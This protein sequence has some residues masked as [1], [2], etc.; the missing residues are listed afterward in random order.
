M[1]NNAFAEAMF[2]LAD[3]PVLAIY[4]LY[5]TSRTKNAYCRPG[6]GHHAI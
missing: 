2:D 5:G 3:D 4:L 1:F 6:F